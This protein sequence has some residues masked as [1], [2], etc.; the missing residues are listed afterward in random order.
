MANLG[1]RAAKKN[2]SSNKIIQAAIKVFGEKPY[3]KATL[4]DVAI[5]AGVSQGLVSQ[6]FNNKESLYSQT[7]EVMLNPII[8]GIEGRTIDDIIAIVL[9]MCKTMNPIYIPSQNFWATFVMN[10]NLPVSITNKFKDILEHARVLRMVQNAMNE[11]KIINGDPYKRLMLF[12]KAVVSTIKIYRGANLPYPSDEIFFQFIYDNAAL[13]SITEKDKEKY[14]FHESINKDFELIAA[15]SISKGTL[16]LLHTS[17]IANEVLAGRNLDSL[18][19]KNCKYILKS[20]VHPD[21]LKYFQDNAKTEVIL[22]ALKKDIAYYLNFRVIINNKPMFIKIKFTL[23]ENNHDYLIIGIVNIDDEMKVIDTKVQVEKEMEIKKAVDKVYESIGL[24]NASAFSQEKKFISKHLVN[25]N[26]LEQQ[27]IIKTSDYKDKYEKYASYIDA[28]NAYI[29]D[30]VV[31]EDKQ[32]L[33]DFVTPEKIRYEMKDKDEVSLIFKINVLDKTEYRQFQ[34]ERGLD[35]DH[36]EAGVIDINDS[37]RIRDEIQSKIQRKTQMDA[38]IL[39]HLAAKYIA[40]YYIDIETKESRA[41]ILSDKLK[42]DTGKLLVQYKTFDEQIFH[43][44]HDSVHQEDQQG[45]MEFVSTFKEKLFLQRSVSYVFR[46]K[47]NDLYYYYQVEATKLDNIEDDLKSLLVSFEDIDQQYKEDLAKQQR[48]EEARIAAET[49]SQAK[50]TF[51]FNM[52]HDIRTPMNAIIGFT[53]KAERNIDNHEI[54]RECLEK[55]QV[56]N[57]YLLNLINDVL[58][59]ARIESGKVSLEES[60]CN[61]EEQADKLTELFLNQAN[62]KNIKFMTEFSQIQHKFIYAD[63]L[64]VTQIISNIVSN[65]IKYTKP[66]GSITYTIKEIPS[67]SP[68]KYAYELSIAD[69][70]IGMT[71]DY[72]AKIF[73]QF[74][75][76]ENTTVSG[77]QGTG[78]GMSIVKKLVDM[79]GGEIKVESELGVGTTITLK[80]EFRKG[81]SSEITTVEE[82]AMVE[83]GTLDGCKVLLVEDNELNREIAC[84]ILAEAGAIVSSA[85][86]GSVAVKMLENKTME[87]YDIILM[88][89]QMPYMNGYDATKII[90]KMKTSIANVPIIAMTANAFDED[91]K[92]AFDAGMDGH[93]AKPVDIQVLISTIKKFKK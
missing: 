2:D 29:D 48:L 62:E 64:R 71:K 43:F 19:S 14:S 66:G 39:K 10:K 67:V 11:G 81:A 70:G 3:E 24:S 35:D 83:G 23:D 33:R 44:I 84:D 40:L 17:N 47:F 73:D 63:I 5:E 41:Y 59:M 51:L 13:S 92:K 9:N 85:D 58:D 56:S 53:Q 69:T 16:R 93:I 88:D 36:V 82:T 77:I 32:Q 20:I 7:I 76:A 12:F 38:G 74:S 89:I 86:D 54:V 75:R 1:I 52:S 50:T 78:L 49:A 15:I 37:I 22:H 30:V 79:M 90:R 55:V 27:V 34:I 21:D 72:Q 60:S 65:A 61:I 91:K 42:Q 31:E 68:E 57:M 45:F 18:D 28:I 6:R 46:R 25:L 26:T 87:D 4:N 8:K 80:L